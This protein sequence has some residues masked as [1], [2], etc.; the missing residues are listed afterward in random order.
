MATSG[1]QQLPSKAQ[2]D[3]EGQGGPALPAYLPAATRQAT[4]RVSSLGGFV[5]PVQATDSEVQF[6]ILAYSPYAFLLLSA[7]D[8]TAT[9]QGVC[10]PSSPPPSLPPR[11]PS[12][13]R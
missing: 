7:A 12:W 8:M 11:V 4:L 6:L 5:D 10:G 13:T 1:V 3:F 9:D 2:F